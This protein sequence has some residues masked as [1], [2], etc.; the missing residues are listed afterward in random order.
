MYKRIFSLATLLSFC[1]SC[2][3]GYPATAVQGENASR[4]ITVSEP[5]APVCLSG[6]KFYPGQPFKLSFIIDNGDNI[7]SEREIKSQ[8]EKLIRYFLAALTIPGDE[9]W[10]NLGPGEKNRVAPDILS[11]TELGAGMLDE[12][13]LLKRLA[14]SLTYPETEVGKRYWDEIN[15]VGAWSPR[16][17]SG[18]GN[19]APTQVLN[20][21]WIVPK[22]VHIYEGGDMALIGDSSLK[23]L[24]EDNK[25]KALKDNILPLI[26]QDVNHGKNF[27][28]LRQ[29]CSAVILAAWFK[30]KIMQQAGTPYT[31]YLNKA[32]VAGIDGN[33]PALREKI[34][35]RYLEALK[36]G[37]Y[38]YIRSEWVGANGRS[39]VQRITK[40]HYFSGGV[41]AK[42]YFTGVVNTTEPLTKATVL[43]NKK[44]TIIGADLLPVDLPNGSAQDV[45]T[46]PW[47]P[48]PRWIKVDEQGIPTSGAIMPAIPSMY[49][50]LRNA[51][52]EALAGEFTA[53]LVSPIFEPSYFDHRKTDEPGRLEYAKEVD[54]YLDGGSAVCNFFLDDSPY[55]PMSY[56]LFDTRDCDLRR[57]QGHGKTLIEKYFYLLEHKKERVAE[58]VNAMRTFVTSSSGRNDI[59]E[60][61]EVLA[62]RILRDAR[63]DYLPFILARLPSYRLLKIY[64]RSDKDIA[65]DPE[66]GALYRELVDLILFNQYWMYKQ[67]RKDIEYA[68]VRGLKVLIDIP[69]FT[70]IMG[71]EAAR[72]PQWL[73]HNADGS[74]KSP[75]RSGQF[76][77]PLAKRKDYFA[78]RE[79]L[80]F[81]LNHFGFNGT[82]QDAWPESLD[83][84]NWKPAANIHQESKA[85]L[86]VENS[87]DPRLTDDHLDKRSRDLGALSIVAQ[88]GSGVN[89]RGAMPNLDA[90]LFGDPDK[91]ENGLFAVNGLTSV[92]MPANHDF[93][94]VPSKYYPLFD[95][96]GGD[97]RDATIIKSIHGLTAMACSLYGMSFGATR[98]DRR[99]INSRPGEEQIWDTQ[100]R[101][102]G[103]D[104]R[105]FFQRLNRIRRAYPF[106]LNPRNI[107][108]KIVA[109]YGNG[110]VVQVERY[111]QDGKRAIV[112]LHNISGYTAT[113]TFWVDYGHFG[114]DFSKPFALRDLS[115]EGTPEYVFSR[116]K[117]TLVDNS[118][119]FKLEPGESHIFYLGPDAKYTPTTPEPVKATVEKKIGGIGLKYDRSNMESAQ[120][121]SESAVTDSPRQPVSLKYFSG[122]KPYV[123]SVKEAKGMREAIEVLRF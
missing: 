117:G 21:I 118:M 79:A 104:L 121:F 13:Y 54:A 111:S 46:E 106:L 3:S 78:A 63:L 101:D 84:G 23:V 20:K 96:L 36:Q 112:S 69:A 59:L 12:D 49:G 6:I 14:A 103:Y 56:Y 82:R 113:G 95:G 10:V 43:S 88:W 19:P 122:F 58:I 41:N 35:N 4:L 30:Q 89:N 7:L 25:G 72:H 34:Y 18:R 98:G 5:C 48:Y 74:I 114:I 77:Q 61:A 44:I 51:I 93:T 52:N 15:G 24:S 17:L 92:F 11:Q 64:N 47:N 81:L 67:V 100:Y 45:F 109:R 120:D 68:Q 60:G 29:I 62:M 105:P 90:V 87:G 115:R 97:D 16:P 119:F 50:G 55:A 123:T 57:V 22:H 75:G 8:S 94:N 107:N 91:G 37:A 73:E 27:A 33:D 110:A 26:E 108:M 70:S 32:K 31:E 80:K 71:V 42:D 38:N 40:R 65:Q 2:F 28:Q 1:L 53:I 116:E 9:L 83:A 102:T 39:P 99:E 86:L 76:W 66:Y 85:L